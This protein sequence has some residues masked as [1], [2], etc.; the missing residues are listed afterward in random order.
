[1]DNQYLFLINILTNECYRHFR[2][3]VFVWVVGQYHLTQNINSKHIF[4]CRILSLIRLIWA[5]LAGHLLH[6]C[7]STIAWDIGD[8]L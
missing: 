3:T 2:L 4:L 1:M 5:S 7:T 6:Q 8:P